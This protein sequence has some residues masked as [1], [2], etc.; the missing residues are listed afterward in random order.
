[1]G[2]FGEGRPPLEQVAPADCEALLR[3]GTCRR[4]RPLTH[5]TGAG[6]QLCKRSQLRDPAKRSLWPTQHFDTRIRCIQ[7]RFTVSS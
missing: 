2:L 4:G 6:T 7:K 1:V 3:A 5:L